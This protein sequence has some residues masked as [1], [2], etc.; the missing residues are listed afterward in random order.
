MDELDDSADHIAANSIGESHV[1][2]G[3]SSIVSD[4]S[5]AWGQGTARSMVPAPPA[6]PAGSSSSAASAVVPQPLG[7]KVLYI[8]TVGAGG[9]VLTGVVFIGKATSSGEWCG[10]VQ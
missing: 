8:I 6:G 5:H 9:I 7:A 2:G 1:A 4:G 3:P 10:A